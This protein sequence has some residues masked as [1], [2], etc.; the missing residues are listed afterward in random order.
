MTEYRL[1]YTFFFEAA[2]CEQMGLTMTAYQMF[3][4]C[5]IATCGIRNLKHRTYR[6]DIFMRILGTTYAAAADLYF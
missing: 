1:Q 3:A 5:R 2:G 6:A 4:V